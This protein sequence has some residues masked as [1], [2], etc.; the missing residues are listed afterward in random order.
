MNTI[1]DYLSELKK[2]LQG[3]DSALVQDAL[4]DAEEYLTDALAGV[5]EE[6]PGLSETDAFSLAVERYGLPGEI[7][8]EYI[9]I[10]KRTGPYSPNVKKGKS[11]FARFFGIFAD[12]KTWGAVLFILISLITGCIYFSWSAAGISLT[13]GLILFIFGL[14]V[15]LFYLYSLRGIAL[16]E[17]RL[18][19][20]LLGVRMPHR[21][22]FM[23]KGMGWKEQLKMLFKEKHTWFTLIYTI[24]QLPLGVI[25]FSL[26]IILTAASLSAC[27]FPFW[28][29]G[30]LKLN[31]LVSS[32]NFTVS[33]WT[34]PLFILGGI[35]LL[36]LTLWMCRG[37][38]WLHGKWARLM[39]VVE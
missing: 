6:Q 14:F 21:P 34:T 1:S 39:L 35:L 13:L 26:F 30:I 22:L 18:V 32:I 29:N 3:R 25:Y 8:Q 33:M 37:I 24:L 7:A 17:G 27:V 19:E 5:K 11:I 31:G 15:L 12:S 36:T 2:N 4:A 20:G 9:S 10:E 23:P 16:L 28:V 38:G